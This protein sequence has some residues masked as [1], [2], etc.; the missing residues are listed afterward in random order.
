MGLEFW[1]NPASL[2]ERAKGCGFALYLFE[3]FLGHRRIIGMDMLDDGFQVFRRSFGPGYLVRLFHPLRT[4]PLLQFGKNLIL[5][6]RLS[7]KNVF[8]THGYEL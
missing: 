6:L 7:F 1:D 2:G 8:L 3:V 5:C 4:Q